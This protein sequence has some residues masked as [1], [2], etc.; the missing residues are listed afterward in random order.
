MNVIRFNGMSKLILKRGYWNWNAYAVQTADLKEL[1]D[2][3][4]IPQV[5]CTGKFFVIQ[6]YLILILNFVQKCLKAKDFQEKLA[7]E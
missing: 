5:L 2:F 6:V 7:I 1:M 3:L 4:E